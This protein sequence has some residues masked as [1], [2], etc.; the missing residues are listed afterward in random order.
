M[1]TIAKPFTAIILAADRTA[2]DPVAEATGAPCKALAP[3]GGIP[4]VL[5]VLT[6]LQQ[7]REVGPCILCGPSKEIISQSPELET[8][9]AKHRI[10]WIPPRETPSTSAFEA[11]QLIKDGSPVLLTTADHA[12]LTPAVVDYFCSQ[13]RQADRDITVGLAP[14]AMLRNAYPHC[15]RTVSKFRDGSY[16]TCNLFAF[17]TPQ[18]YK[19]ADFWK[20]VEQQ[21]KKP[22]RIIGICGW[23]TVVRYLLGWLTL[24]GG[25]QRIARR[26]GLRG[27]PII[28]IHPEAA[29]DVDTVGDLVLVNDIVAKREKSGTP[30]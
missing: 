24:E 4:M 18:S 2:A 7:A 23:W 17:L 9:I 15:R 8:I 3:V 30:E 19:A 27:K 21:R 13:S 1:T 16:C 28:M 25:V 26:M 22:L 14:Y 10:R 5:R 12:L 11:L 20:R 29:V 6:A